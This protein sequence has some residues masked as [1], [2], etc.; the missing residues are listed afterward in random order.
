MNTIAFII[1]GSNKSQQEWVNWNT[2]FRPMYDA[3]ISSGNTP[4]VIYSTPDTD[5][6]PA[7]DIPI[8]VI[9][10][11]KDY[12]KPLWSIGLNT[13]I[14]QLLKNTPPEHHQSTS[15]IPISFETN[16]DIKNIQCLI[17]VVQENQRFVGYRKTPTWL[18][19]ENSYISSFPVG[20]IELW[21][22][23]QTRIAEHGSER[24][25]QDEALLQAM[26][27]FA[28]NTLAHYTLSDFITYGLFNSK[29]DG[30]GGMEDW[31]FILRSKPN[32]SQVIEYTDIRIPKLPPSEDI[33]EFQQKKLLREVSALKKILKITHPEV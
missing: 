25:A 1:R 11:S 12:E 31:E 7:T 21:T 24:L 29:T 30:M 33:V 17:N 20:V 4:T 28:R 22:N 8:S 15:V 13:P 19:S 10:I 26:I 14:Q 2:R 5:V 3:L 16:I 9:Q 6:V 18:V 27:L 23:M 32:F